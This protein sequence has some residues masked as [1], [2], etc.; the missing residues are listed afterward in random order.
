MQVLSLCIFATN[1][2]VILFTCFLFFCFLFILTN[3]LNHMQ[4]NIVLKV[5]RRRDFNG[6]S[7]KKFSQISS[8]PLL[9]PSPPSFSMAENSSDG[10][11]QNADV[12]ISPSIVSWLVLFQRYLSQK[13]TFKADEQPRNIERNMHE[14]SRKSH[15][16][17]SIRIRSYSGP[18]SV[19]MRENTDQN[20]SEYGYFL[21]SE[22]ACDNPAE[23]M[24]IMENLRI[25]SKRVWKGACVKVWEGQALVTYVLSLQ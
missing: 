22:S 6:Q 9:P 23:F 3:K 17:K 12:E 8:S 1:R 25:N 15:C 16:V 24:E 5:L 13:Y 7:P 21:R 20:N 18:Y 2:I 19:R 11:A 10:P 14:I 4:Q